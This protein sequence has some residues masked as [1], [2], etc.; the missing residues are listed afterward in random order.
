LYRGECLD[1]TMKNNKHYHKLRLRNTRLYASEH[2]TTY[3]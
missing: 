2:G 1:D 3:W